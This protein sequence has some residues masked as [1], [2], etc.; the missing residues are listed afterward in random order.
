MIDARSPLAVKI[1][2]A[3]PDAYR[4]LVVSGPTPALA[5]ELL[6]SVTPEQLLVGAVKSPDAGRAML[7]GLW[8]WH[9]ALDESHRISQGIDDSTGALWHA[10][11]HRREGDFSNSK[12]WLARAGR[13]P[14]YPM[15]ASSAGAVVNPLPADK[16]LLRVVMGGWNPDGFVDLVEN[17]RSDPA[18]PRFAVAQRLQ[19]L[20]WQ[21][22]FDFCTREARG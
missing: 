4:L 13:H 16:L 1:L 21:A 22:L 20:E 11:M 12:Y 9:D 8:L 18:D 19:K 17:V 5:H 15:L 3:N 2:D 6:D 14:V 7:A 10:I